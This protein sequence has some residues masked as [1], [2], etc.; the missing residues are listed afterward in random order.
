MGS[1][2]DEF[3]PIRVHLCVNWRWVFCCIVLQ[4]SGISLAAV[5]YSGRQNVAQEARVH[6]DATVDTQV[7]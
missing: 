4:V 2:L 7:E 3:S 6:M 5:L 1:R